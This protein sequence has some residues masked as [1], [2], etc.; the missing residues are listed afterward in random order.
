M[1]DYAND[2]ADENDGKY[3]VESEMTFEGLLKSSLREQDNPEQAPM[4]AGDVEKQASTSNAGTSSS[5]VPEMEREDSASPQRIDLA[6]TIGERVA[7]QASKLV[8]GKTNAI[9]HQTT[10]TL[11]ETT[12][13]Q[14]THY[15]V[16]QITDRSYQRHKAELAIKDFGTSWSYEPIEPPGD[17]IRHAIRRQRQRDLRAG[18]TPV[19]WLSDDQLET[20]G[21]WYQNRAEIAFNGVGERYGKSDDEIEVYDQYLVADLDI[22]ELLLGGDLSG[23]TERQTIVVRENIREIV[24]PNLTVPQSLAEYFQQNVDYPVFGRV[25]FDE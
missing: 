24:S 10:Y 4:G 12:I 3:S 16:A 15:F 14:Q 1:T 22:E 17:A 21:D 20:V 13:D 19:E 6:D 2:S 25:V 7:E 23:L 5:E 11:A 9:G 8:E 18:K